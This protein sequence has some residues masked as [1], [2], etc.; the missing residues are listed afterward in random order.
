[1]VY[2][3][4]SFT[5]AG[6]AIVVEDSPAGRLGLT[7]CYD[8]RFPELYQMLRFEHNAQVLLVPSAFTKVTGEAHWEILL[9]ARAIETQCFVIA[10]AQAGKHNEKRESYGGSLIID[11]W[12]TVIARLP[13]RL[14]TG[15]A[16]AD[17]NLSQIDAIRTRMPIATHGKFSISWKSSSP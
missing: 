13:D 12:G 17:L 1:M 14:S 11:P 2:K 15:I 4:S 9:R 6:D 8:L 16:I 7:V 5:T 3:E 10:A